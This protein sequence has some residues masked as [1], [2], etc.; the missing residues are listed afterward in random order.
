MVDSTHAAPPRLTLFA[1]ALDRRSLPRP[2]DGVRVTRLDSLDELEAD[3]GPIVVWADDEDALVAL[4]SAGFP[5]PTPVIALAAH[6]A[7]GLD[8]V[9]RGTDD[10]AR[11]GDWSDLE[12]KWR[13]AVARRAASQ[14]RTFTQDAP[15]E[16]LFE[17]AEAPATS[18]Q[19]LSLVRTLLT[20]AVR[21]I[22]T[23]DAGSVLL[24]GS[25]GRFNF[26]AAVGYELSRL[27]KVTLGPDELSLGGR[28]EGTSV[29]LILDIARRGSV[30][31]PQ[32]RKRMRS[33]TGKR[34]RVSLAVPVAV[35]GELRAVHYLDTLGPNQEPD[36]TDIGLA[37]EFGAQ[38]ALVLER[39]A[40][41]RELRT[42]R[43]ASLRTVGL[44]LERR[45]LETKGHTDRV[46]AMVERL[47]E[48][49]GLGAEERQALR[50]G[51]YLHDVG[52]IALPDRIL[53][54][55]GRLTEGEFD[56]VRQH[57][58]IGYEMIGELPFLPASARHLVRHHHERWNGGGYPDNLAGNGIPV[59]ARLFSMV[60]VYDALLSCRP[61]KPAW[62]REQ[63]LGMVRRGAG[64]DFDPDMA[65][66]FLDM[67]E[68]S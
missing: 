63:A 31:D 5:A 1:S 67:M 29:E 41:V 36:D 43:D 17:L 23:V 33:A 42:T 9:R 25:D 44:L 56:Q 66:A 12:R 19:V 68:C 37:E 58:D 35:Q 46:V 30:L 24:Q 62:S 49:V 48:H 8:A 11:P 39:G 55:P 26:V 47:A 6:E 32:R 53:F 59:L 34:I 61:Y 64:V 16:L 65:G 13:S 2:P 22:P 27:R 57:A 45:D 28:K 7:S 18:G 15:R 50:W 10:W 3:C 20:R 54:K 4:E 14:S 38:L 51:A 40:F 52:K 21:S 60:D